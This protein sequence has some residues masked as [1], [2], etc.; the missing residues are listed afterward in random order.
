MAHQDENYSR[1]YEVLRKGKCVSDQ[2]LDHP[3][4]Q[5]KKEWDRLST[6]IN[7]LILID[8]SRIIIPIK[9]RKEVLRRLHL[10]HQ[11]VVP[12]KAR[13]LGTV[14]WHGLMNEIVQL[15]GSCDKCQTYRSN[16][17]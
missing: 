15:V 5:F 4:Q 12:T 6:D 16:Q 13:A 11:G 14:F 3:A 8:S 17:T 2:A 1:V 9:A 7:G 10:S